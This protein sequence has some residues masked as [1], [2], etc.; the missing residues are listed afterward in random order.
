MEDPGY[1]NYIH[2]FFLYAVGDQGPENLEIR[3][4]RAE[5]N[6]KIQNLEI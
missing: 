2:F 1:A 5:R 6:L 3:N 4:Y